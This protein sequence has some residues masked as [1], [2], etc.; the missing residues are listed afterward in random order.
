MI[1]RSRRKKGF[2]YLFSGI[3]GKVSLISLSI[4]LAILLFLGSSYYLEEKKVITKFIFSQLNLIAEQ[5]KTI[6]IGWLEATLEKTE[7]IGKNLGSKFIERVG[8]LPE[9]DKAIFKDVSKHSHFFLLEKKGRLSPLF[10]SPSSSRFLKKYENIMKSIVQAREPMIFF[11]VSDENKPIM[12]IVA[13]VVI[14]GG[15]Q[16][17]IANIVDVEEELLPLLKH[18]LEGEE[19]GIILV[20]KKG[21]VLLKPDKGGEKAAIGLGIVAATGEEGITELKE[22]EGEILVAYRHIPPVSLGLVLTEDKKRALAPLTALKIRTVSFGA[23]SF[24]IFAI[25][26]WVTASR[27]TSPII[28]LTE[29]A[30]RIALGKLDERIEIDR[31]DELGEL[32]RSFN[33][34]VEQLNLSLSAISAKS[35]ELTEAV[36]ELGQANRELMLKKE[37][38]EKT[39]D[40]LVRTEKLA[41]LGQLAAVI[42]HELRNPLA[43]INNASY[44]LSEKITDKQLMEF[45]EI[46]NRETKIANE[47]IAHVLSFAKPRPIAL[48]PVNLKKVFSDALS[49]VKDRG[50]CQRSE[51]KVELPKS[52]IK[53]KGDPEKIRV[54]LVN[55]ILN[56]CQ[57]MPK[58]GKLTIKAERK[59]KDLVII[60]KD[61][62]IGIHNEKIPLIF[63]PFHST[64]KRGVGLG[65]AICRQVVEEHGGRIEVES[66]P[67]KG[68]SFYV[69]LPIKGG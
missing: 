39:Q 50:D 11:E 33:S 25:I 7:K 44:Y 9:E 12:I 15:I 8:M 14:K 60:V 49:T 58:G 53:I 38:L 63:E 48:S 47:I 6:I 46:I 29:G 1:A 13:P 35:E 19:V 5:D 61:E 10:P 28:K 16:G 3:K 4:L 21:N 64:R 17:V 18:R 62:G 45:I 36:V 20:T 66:K 42:S 30:R 67:G 2:L 43:V 27:L 41:A 24:I 57:A 59:K 22:D 34:M 37:E 40:E 23:I 32:A 69:F 31:K 51:I 55:L 26:I 54:A 52:P 68:T 65:L 56:G